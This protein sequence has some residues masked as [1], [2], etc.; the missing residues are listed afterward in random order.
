MKNSVVWLT[1]L[2]GAGK[3]TIAMELE[4]QLK[5]YGVNTCI[6]DGD[7]LRAGLNKDLGFDE[8]SR[9]ENI[10]RAAEVSKLLLNSGIT[11]IAALISP[12][13]KDRKNACELIGKDKFVEVFVNTSIHTCIQR[14]PKGLYAKALKKEISNFAGIDAPYEQP[15]QPDLNLITENHTAKDL[16]VEIVNY[17]K[18]R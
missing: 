2:S 8:G 4:T 11:V 10:R 3:S 6:L 12:Y 17:L 9:T 5:I 13:A 1:G 7:V 14:D 16:A 18:H 15:T